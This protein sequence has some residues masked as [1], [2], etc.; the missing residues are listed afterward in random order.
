MT[1]DTAYNCKKVINEQFDFSA[2][3][4]INWVIADPHLPSAKLKSVSSIIKKEKKAGSN[5]SIFSRK[6][7]IEI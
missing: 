6:N 3:S 4:G 2:T 7:K 5:A 1:G